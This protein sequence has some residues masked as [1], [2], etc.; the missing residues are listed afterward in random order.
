LH[1][2]EIIDVCTS[3]LLPMCMNSK[4]DFI[5]T[6]VPIKECEKPVVSIAHMSYEESIHHIEE[7]LFV[8]SNL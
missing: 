3:Y 1:Q 7:F 2:I 8:E 4:Y 6:T 5:I